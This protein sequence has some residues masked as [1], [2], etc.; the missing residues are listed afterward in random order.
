MNKKILGIF[1]SLLAVAMLTLPMSMVFAKNNPRLIDV[2]GQFWEI[3]STR[4]TRQAGES[5]NVIT[6]IIE[7]HLG[8][9]GNFVGESFGHSHLVQHYQS[10][11]GHTTAQNI[12]T[13]E[14]AALVV[15]DGEYEGTYEGTLTIKIST[16]HWRII[17]GTDDFANLHGQ[18]TTY[19]ITPFPSLTF[20]YEGT[21]HFDP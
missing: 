3:E 9:S 11:K 17:S 1:V 2:S 7:G 14:D 20:G 18:G 16:G 13:L 4:D 21:V 19:F 5:A 15:T 8:W 6:T 10:N 12:N